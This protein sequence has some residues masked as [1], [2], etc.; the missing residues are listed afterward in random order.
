MLTP[1]EP[2][3]DG[4]REDHVYCVSGKVSNIEYAT[5]IMPGVTIAPTPIK[6]H[7]LPPG[8]PYQHVN[9]EAH[10]TNSFLRWSCR[11][12]RCYQHWRQK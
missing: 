4:P 12:G 10:K 3:S 8:A 7:A 5:S 6:L 2:S 1:K 11:Q 9:T